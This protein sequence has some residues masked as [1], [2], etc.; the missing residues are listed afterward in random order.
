LTSLSRMGR[1]GQPGTT[2]AFRT[3]VGSPFA[4]ISIRGYRFVTIWFVEGQY[5]RQ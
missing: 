5:T 2:Y 3:K 4:G 1:P